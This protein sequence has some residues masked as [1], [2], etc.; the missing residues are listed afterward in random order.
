MLTSAAANYNC[1]FDTHPPRCPLI[2]CFFGLR[3]RTIIRPVMVISGLLPVAC[4]LFAFRTGQ[5]SIRN[6]PQKLDSLVWNMFTSIKGERNWKVI[7]IFHYSS[8]EQLFS[9][10][11]L[12][13]KAGY[14]YSSVGTSGKRLHFY[15]ILNCVQHIQIETYHWWPETFSNFIKFEFWNRLI[16]IF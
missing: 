11:R 15:N 10:C 14:V 6:K 8:N 1:L 12:K 9:F 5:M 2:R 4:S 7:W 3:S 13:W 16:K